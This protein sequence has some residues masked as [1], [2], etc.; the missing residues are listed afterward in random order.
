MA[1]KAK[2]AGLG[3]VVESATP[4]FSDLPLELTDRGLTIAKHIALC[5]KGGDN[6]RVIALSKLLAEEAKANE[7]GD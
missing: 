7:S 4:E 2:K 5:A 3:P 6:Q 1:K